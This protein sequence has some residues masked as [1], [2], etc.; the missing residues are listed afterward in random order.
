MTVVA[1]LNFS[2][3]RAIVSW[4]DV[5]EFEPEFLSRLVFA[6]WA[7]SSGRMGIFK[8]LDGLLG[9]LQIPDCNWVVGLF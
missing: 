5:A 4:P 6:I 1:L 3:L 9:L 7:A 2:S 8:E